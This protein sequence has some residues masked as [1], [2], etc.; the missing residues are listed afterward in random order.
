MLVI[1]FGYWSVSFSDAV[2]VSFDSVLF[3]FVDISKTVITDIFA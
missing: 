2:F 3:W 1:V